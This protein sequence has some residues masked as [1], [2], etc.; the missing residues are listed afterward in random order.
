MLTNKTRLEYDFSELTE[1]EFIPPHIEVLCC[2]FNY[3]TKLP[4]LPKNLKQIFCD[5]NRLTEIPEIHSNLEILFCE[6]NSI[7]ELPLLPPSLRMLS[8]CN[9]PLQY[10]PFVHPEN[11]Q[12]LYI[13]ITPEMIQICAEEDFQII[14]NIRT[15]LKKDNIKTNIYKNIQKELFSI[16]KP[17]HNGLK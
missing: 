11:L 7:T 14:E 6:H 12:T 10:I 15:F 5:C 4:P 9:N 17:F 1:I 3:L 16:E 2:E 13:D 8:C